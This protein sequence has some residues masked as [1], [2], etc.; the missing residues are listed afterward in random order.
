MLN[1]I[2]T[3]KM[4]GYWV[5]SGRVLLVK[6][7]GGKT[8]YN[9]IQAYAPTAEASKEEITEFYW[10]QHPAKLGYLEMLGIS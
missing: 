4:K 10:Q 2:V 6:L 8:D 9:L 7:K 1:S 3:K 5:V